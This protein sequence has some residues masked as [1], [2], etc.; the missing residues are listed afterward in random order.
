MMVLSALALVVLS[1]CGGGGAS[2]KRSSGRGEVAASVKLTGR[3]GDRVVAQSESDAV[4]VSIA[5]TGVYSEDG[6][7]F[8][9][10]TASVE[11]SLSVGYARVSVLNVL[12]R[13]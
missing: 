2:S 13:S 12:D 9:P 1:G 3:V 8:D 10:I 6:T 4:E 7:E 11:I 5:V